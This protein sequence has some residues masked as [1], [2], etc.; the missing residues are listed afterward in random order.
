[1]HNIND[2]MLNKNA[3]NFQ[4]VQALNYVK[5]H[6]N[7]DIRIK[8]LADS[9]NMSESNF[10]RIFQ[11][12]M[13]MIPKDYVNMIRIREASK[14]LLSSYATMDEVA[15]QVG[16]GNVSSFNRNFKKIIGMTPYQWK[17]SPDNYVG[18]MLDLKISALKGW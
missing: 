15:Y 13:H 9:C 5:K 11:E 6:Y 17:R 8:E 4:I 2:E 10:R 14:I 18:Q 1:M 3:R 16:Y 12:C 7:Q